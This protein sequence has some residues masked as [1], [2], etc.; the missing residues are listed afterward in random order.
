MNQDEFNLSGE[1]IKEIQKSREEYDKGKI[2]TLD[3]IK[4]K[5]KL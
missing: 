4:K 2:Y 3:E 1:T 5:L